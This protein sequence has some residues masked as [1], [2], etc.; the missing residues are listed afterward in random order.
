MKYGLAVMIFF[1]SLKLAFCASANLLPDKEYEGVSIRVEQNV[2]APFK[3]FAVGV[4]GTEYFPILVNNASRMRM[5]SFA[6][7]GHLFSSM[8]ERKGGFSAIFDADL[9]YHQSFQVTLRLSSFDIPY[10]VGDRLVLFP[11]KA[12]HYDRKGSRFW[13]LNIS[14]FRH[15]SA[16]PGMHHLVG[17][18]SRVNLGGLTI[19]ATCPECDWCQMQARG[20]CGDAMIAG[21]CRAYACVISFNCS[22]S[23]GGNC[24]YTCKAP[25]L[26]C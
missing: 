16:E 14:E 20:S 7:G 9:A 6:I 1:L 4:T 13:T 2:D 15:I 5:K 24:S 22:C 23:G 18:Y 3:V 11:I 12:Q 8:G 10:Q 17:N 26:C 25:D 21:V 19:Q